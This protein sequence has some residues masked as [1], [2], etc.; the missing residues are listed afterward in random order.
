M[1]ETSAMVDTGP[2]PDTLSLS[3]VEVKP[4]LTY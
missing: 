4:S 3:T 2:L 1:V